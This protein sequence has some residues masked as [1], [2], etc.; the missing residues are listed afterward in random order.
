M[1]SLT[2]MFK[3]GTLIMNMPSYVFVLNLLE[4]MILL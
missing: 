1:K 2:L 4:E 3:N